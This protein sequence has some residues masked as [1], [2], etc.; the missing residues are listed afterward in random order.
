MCYSEV[1]VGHSFSSKSVLQVNS[2]LPDG[3]VWYIINFLFLNV[4]TICWT[5]SNFNGFVDKF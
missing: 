5:G 2:T 3:V 1:V 4:G